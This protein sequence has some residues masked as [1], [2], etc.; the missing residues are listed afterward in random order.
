MNMLT[1]KILGALVVALISS[2]PIASAEEAARLGSDLTPIGAEKSGNADGT[3]PAWTGGLTKALPGWPNEKNDRPNPYNDDPVKFT[4]TAANYK[5][6]ADKL[7]PGTQALFEIYPDDFKMDIYPTRR[8]AAF[9]E[10][11]YEATKHNV[12]KAK[13]VG[14]GTGVD[15]AGGGIPFPIPESGLEVIWNYLLSN[16]NTATRSVTA[17]ESVVFNNGQRQDWTY[18][19]IIYSPFQD[20][21]NPAAEKD[22][23]LKLA[24]M[25]TQPARDAGEGVVVIDSVNASANPRQA[26]SYDPGERRVRRAPS[27]KFDTPDR[28]LNVIDDVEVYSG[29]PERYNWTL[30]GKKEMYVPYNNNQLNSPENKLLDVTKTPYIDSDMI[31]YELHRVW[32]V[33]GTLKE[34]ERHLYNKRVK[35]IDE[36]SWRILASERYDGSGELWR[37]GFAYPVFAS[38]IPVV[39]GGVNT[40]IDLKKGGYHVV[41]LP[42]EG[43]GYNFSEVPPNDSYFTAAA[44]RRRGR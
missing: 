24:L 6:H 25:Y 3:I 30:I 41:G 32:V 17:Q 20:L 26:W 8:T 31:R 39:A 37:I 4:I 43:L 21:S 29:S 38:E 9:P 5:E 16:P 42:A 13:L 44:L 14:E 12:S 7:T 18:E 10:S 22:T 40:N 19:S 11:F 35:Y 1:K 23:L 2:A 34:E 28:A 15:G 33:E 27:L 36:D